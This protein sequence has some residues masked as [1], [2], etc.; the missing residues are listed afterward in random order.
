MSLSIPMTLAPCP[1]VGPGLPCR[2]ARPSSGQWSVY[3]LLSPSPYLLSPALLPRGAGE[4]PP[5]RLS[6]AASRGLFKQ[7][8]RPLHKTLQMPGSS[9]LVSFCTLLSWC[10]NLPQ[11]QPPS[12]KPSHGLLKSHLLHLGHKDG[13][14][15]SLQTFPMAETGPTSCPLSG[16]PGPRP[17]SGLNLKFPPPF[18]HHRP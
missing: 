14:Q 10:P 8:W 2:A 12:P 1:H 4:G 7:E 15:V 3:H 5:L 6:P 13:T 11:T 17:R 18:Q 16:R 9:R